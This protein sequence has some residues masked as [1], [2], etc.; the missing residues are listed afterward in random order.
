MRIGIYLLGS[1]GDTLVALPALWAVRHQYPDSHISLFTDVT[2]GQALVRSLD[3]L[4][5]SGLVDEIVEYSSG[6]ESAGRFRK[7]M[8]ILKLWRGL[9]AARLDLMIYLVQ[10]YRDK[11]RVGRDRLFFRTCGI[12]RLA[13]FEGMP[14]TPVI[15]RGALARQ[16]TQADQF[17]Y[18]LAAAGLPVPPPG[19]ARADLNLG[20]RDYA[21]ADAWTRTG[22]DDG[23]RRRVAFGPG[24]KMPAK[25]WP[26]ERFAEAGR[27]LIGEYDVWPVIFGGA[28]DRAAG[29]R[30]LAAWGRGSMAA[31]EL[32]IRASA[33]ALGRCACYVGNDT[34]TM[35]LAASAG[36]P[37]VAI[38]SARDY[39]GLWEP[40]G[41]GHIVLRTEAPCSGCY[42]QICP[43]NDNLC[44]NRIAVDEVVAACRKALAAAAAG[45][46]SL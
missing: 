8:G 15:R 9:R 13:G 6:S 42:A 19:Q 23:G 39:P 29:V 24:T 11:P 22:P 37:C 46:E 31:G 7:G 33:A 32:G 28:E 3:V 1:L 30:L 20:P 4:E 2:I 21:K 34:G 35:H 18:R 12:R 10:G 17:L 40:Y 41:P 16:P 5:G 44:L 43:R 38:F 26:E 25:L 45:A 14:L 27:Q 36:V